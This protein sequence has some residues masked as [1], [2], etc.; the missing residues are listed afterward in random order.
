MISQDRQQKHH[1]E[2][3]YSCS[4][5]TLAPWVVYRDR[6]GAI[7]N[8]ID[9]PLPLPP[10]DRCS[11]NMC[12]LEISVRDRLALDRTR[13]TEGEGEAFPDEARVKLV[14]CGTVAI[15]QIRQFDLDVDS[16]GTSR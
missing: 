6:Q 13:I 16:V 15:R 10:R 14:D 2:I 11:D 4:S 3:A 5:S 8:V 9:H 12:W 1:C 7:H